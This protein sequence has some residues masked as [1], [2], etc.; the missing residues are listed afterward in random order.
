MHSTQSSL[1]AAFSSPANGIAAMMARV[2]SNQAQAG[3]GQ[4]FTLVNIHVC[5]CC[6]FETSLLETWSWKTTKQERTTPRALAGIQTG[7]GG[8]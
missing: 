1:L 5:I 8:V 3:V 7:Q 4:F 6:A 2:S